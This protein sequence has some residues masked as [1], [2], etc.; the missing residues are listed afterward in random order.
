MA[1]SLLCEQ[2]EANNMPSG[3]S[4]MPSPFMAWHAISLRP[5]RHFHAR[6][7]K[8]SQYQSVMSRFAKKPG[9]PAR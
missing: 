3:T 9:T 2:K 8:I 4:L 5:C 7:I 6:S 1:R